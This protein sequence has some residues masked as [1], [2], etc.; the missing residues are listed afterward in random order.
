[1]SRP[2]LQWDLLSLAG[3]R[4]LTSTLRDRFVEEIK[5]EAYGKAIRNLMIGTP[6]LAFFLE[7]LAAR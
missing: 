7:A 5:P 4:A 3:R 2:C 1:M 6:P